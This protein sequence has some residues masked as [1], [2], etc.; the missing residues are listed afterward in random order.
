MHGQR[1]EHLVVV[2]VVVIH[3]HRAALHGTRPRVRPLQ[4]VLPLRLAPVIVGIEPVETDALVQGI[5]TDVV[6]WKVRITLAFVLRRNRQ[7]TQRK[8]PL[9]QLV[10]GAAGRLAARGGGDVLQVVDYL[11]ARESPSL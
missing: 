9:A 8:R 7:L 5:E 1:S 2:V 11:W 6:N 4:L 3:A 10:E